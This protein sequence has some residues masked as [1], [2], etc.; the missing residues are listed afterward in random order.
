MINDREDDVVHLYVKLSN[1]NIQGEFLTDVLSEV[2]GNQEASF[3]TVLNGLKF[4]GIEEQASRQ[5]ITNNHSLSYIHL[6]FFHK[7]R[8][9]KMGRHG[10]A[11]SGKWP[12]SSCQSS[13]PAKRNQGRPNPTIPACNRRRPSR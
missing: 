6:I 8:M 13:C 9:K 10:M 11:T 3:Y 12:L 2:D 4:A 5:F 1:K 7:K